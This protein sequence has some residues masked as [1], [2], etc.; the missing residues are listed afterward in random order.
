VYIAMNRLLFVVM[1]VR[2]I[3]WAVNISYAC[4]AALIVTPM[5]VVLVR[6]K[7]RH[8]GWVAA[9]LVSFGIAWFCR[10]LDWEAREVL[11]MGSH[12][13]WHTFGALCTVFVIE[14][15]YRVEGERPPGE[16]VNPAAGVPEVRW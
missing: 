1:P 9:G 14:F 4:L 12:W 6:T 13:L 5:V 7:F 16:P 11:S 15:F 3:Q 10:L 2:S 8:A